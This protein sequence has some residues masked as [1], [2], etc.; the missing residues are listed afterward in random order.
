MWVQVV[1]SLRTLLFLIVERTLN[2][3]QRAELG[4]ASRGLFKHAIDNPSLAQLMSSAVGFVADTYASDATA[5]RELLRMI[6]IP[7]HFQRY[8]HAEVPWLARKLE[9]DRRG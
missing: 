7:E 5:S 4:V 1:W 6:F 2:S 8:A 9:A 3:E